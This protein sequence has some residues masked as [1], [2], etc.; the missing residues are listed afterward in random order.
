MA[1]TID[2]SELQ[3]RLDEFLARAAAGERIL[4]RDERGSTVSLGPADLPPAKRRRHEAARTIE[5]VLSD[6]RGA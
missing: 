2:R 4:V 6:D 3:A 5:E 1:T